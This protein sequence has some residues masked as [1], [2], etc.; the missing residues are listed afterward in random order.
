MCDVEGCYKTKQWGDGLFCW[1]HREV[2]RKIMYAITHDRQIPESETWEYV[3]LY[4]R[5]D[6]VLGVSNDR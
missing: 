2:F 1:F 4:C 3:R 5:N 6:L